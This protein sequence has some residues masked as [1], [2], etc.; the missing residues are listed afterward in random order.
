MFKAR[1]LRTAVAAVALKIVAKANEKDALNELAIWAKLKNQTAHNILYGFGQV[2]IP[3]GTHV[4]LKMEYFAHQ[5][6]SVRS[7]GCFYLA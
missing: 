6:F 7:L 5:P 2:H 1:D 3:L 4:V